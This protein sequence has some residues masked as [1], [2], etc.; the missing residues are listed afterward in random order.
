M[1]IGRT[2]YKK[3]NYNELRAAGFNRVDANRIKGA[4]RDT[5]SQAISGKALPEKN[6]NKITQGPTAP[7]SSK[8]YKPPKPPKIHEH[9]SRNLEKRDM[10]PTQKE[11]L[12]KY[13]YIVSYRYKGDTDSGKRVQITITNDKPLYKWEVLGKALE[14]LQEDSQK[15]YNFKEIA[16]SSL[17]VDYV[18]VNNSL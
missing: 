9:I 5:I 12:D 6:L 7:I 16:V 18:I 13:N 2:A 11:Y 1:A 3:A 14:M 17:R 8:G 4:S 15:H 10:D